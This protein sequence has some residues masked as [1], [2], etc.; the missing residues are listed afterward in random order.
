MR[1]DTKGVARCFNGEGWDPQ[2]NSGKIVK[3]VLQSL[4]GSQFQGSCFLYRIKLDKRCFTHGECEES[5]TNEPRRSI[6][7]SR[8]VF[9]NFGAFWMSSA[10]SLPIGTNSNEE[11]QKLK[12]PRK[13]TAKK[14]GHC[15]RGLERIFCSLL[16]K[17]CNKVRNQCYA[18]VARRA[19]S[20]CAKGL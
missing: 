19:D 6:S 11:Q 3:C 15:R 13:P 1:K 7:R 12:P 8:K 5:G 9:T 10:V 2:R 14:P 4:R 16:L 18:A 20:L 17:Q